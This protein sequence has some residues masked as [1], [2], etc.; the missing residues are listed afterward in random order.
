[1]PVCPNAGAESIK[2]VSKI[3]AWIF[4]A[5]VIVMSRPL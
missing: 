3:E 4:F 1:L 2:R 5:V